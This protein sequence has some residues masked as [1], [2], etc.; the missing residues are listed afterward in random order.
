MARS[1][2]TVLTL[3]RVAMTY[4]QRKLRSITSMNL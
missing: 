4:S 1:V 2:P 3:S